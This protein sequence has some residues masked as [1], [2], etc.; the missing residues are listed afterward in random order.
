MRLNRGRFIAGLGAGVTLAACN[1]GGAGIVP[2]PR[3]LSRTGLILTDIHFNP[4]TD[5]LI[6]NTLAQTPIAGWD[7]VFK[8]ST[9]I[10][11]SPY[12]TD[13]NFPLLQSVLTAMKAQNPNPD[14]VFI[15]GDFLA[16][17]LQNFFTQ[18]NMTKNTQ[19]DYV[20]F[21]NK[22]EQYL[23]LKLSQTFPN[24]QFSIT[25]CDW[26]TPFSTSDTF[27]GN[28]FLA[29]FTAAWNT[30]VNQYQGAPNFQTTFA[31]GG[32]YSTAFPIDPKGR[33]VV[34]NTLPWSTGY[35]ATACDGNDNN[36]AVTEL[37]WLTNELA[38]ARSLGQRVWILG[39]I[40]PGV[41]A[42]GIDC[43]KPPSPFYAEPYAS[44]LE[45]LFAKYRGTVTF[46]IFGHEH[47]DDFRVSRD[48]SG[49]LLFGIKITPSVTP[50]DGNNPAFV[51]FTY[52]PTAG[53][54][55]D[56]TTWYLTNL[57]SATTAVPGV[58]ESEYS[59]NATYGQ[60]AMD[61]NGV[62]GAV[63]NILTQPGLQASFM[64]YF[65]SSSPTFWRAGTPLFAPY[66]CAFTNLGLSEFNACYCP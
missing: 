2:A 42:V 25:L 54:I 9:K 11:Y 55:S 36:L 56:A 65:P 15:P 40:P 43:S 46:G 22:T 35:T 1:G 39:H 21:V 53:A 61:S 5:P 51:Q 3:S 14:I 20:A 38:Q 16:H 44:Q 7:A 12:L 33:L 34:L 58:W 6:G 30:A 18:A 10:G 19:A 66:G 32:Y 24:A 52:D 63:N 60:S 59:F 50:A 29:S 23:A 4:L 13:T 28:A 45:A 48:S 57:P 8:T 31:A 41:S 64:R 37:A 17:Y 27:P 62:A 47:L 49:S 26:Y